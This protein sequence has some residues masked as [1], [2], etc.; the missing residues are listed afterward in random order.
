MILDTDKRKKIKFFVGKEIENTQMKGKTTLFVVG[1][2]S[3]PDIIRYANRTHVEHIYLGTSQS[4]NPE[5]ESDWQDWNNLIHNLLHSGLTVTLDYDVKY[6]HEISTKSWIKQ[7]NFIS[8][9]SVKLPNI[10][11]LKNSTI[12][13][14]DITWGATNT[15]VWTHNLAE[16]M[17]K[18]QYT[19]WSEYKGDFE[20][21][22]DNE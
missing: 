20:V 15:G 9:I 5:N 3:V 10:E 19:D 4:F 2:Q 22:V 12:K 14:D 21:K 17:Q 18:E 6:A 1:L 16:L 7:N 11:L 8:M 13:L